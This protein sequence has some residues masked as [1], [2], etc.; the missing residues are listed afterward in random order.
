MAWNKQVVY[1]FTGSKRHMKN[2]SLGSTDHVLWNPIIHGPRAGD[3]SLSGQLEKC[4]EIRGGYKIK[5][6]DENSCCRKDQ[7]QCESTVYE[8]QKG[9]GAGTVSKG[10]KWSQKDNLCKDRFQGKSG[11]CD[12]LSVENGQPKWINGE[13]LLKSSPNG[14]IIYQLN[15]TKYQYDLYKHQDGSWRFK[16]NGFPVHIGFTNSIASTDDGGMKS[17]DTTAQ[18]PQDVDDESWIYTFKV[19]YS[20]PKLNH[21]E[22]KFGHKFYH[23]F[24]IG[25]RITCEQTDSCWS[26]G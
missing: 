25:C 24:S 22:R 9:R 17:V 11:C 4:V 20:D 2:R 19:T 3:P 10:C 18:C 7:A 15:H 1:D 5:D 16:T 23:K 13:Y 14:E 12:K 21:I 26:W 6:E 8:L